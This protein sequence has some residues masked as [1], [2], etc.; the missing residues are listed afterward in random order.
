[1]VIF[2]GVFDLNDLVSPITYHEMSYK[3]CNSWASLLTVLNG[4]RLLIALRIAVKS[5]ECE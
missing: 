3:S 5:N 1:M 2:L 4:V